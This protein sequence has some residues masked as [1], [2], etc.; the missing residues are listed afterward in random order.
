M[1]QTS[2][3]LR[4]KLNVGIAWKNGEFSVSRLIG[5]PQGPDLS[6]RSTT[7]MSTWPTLPGLRGRATAATCS[8]GS[9]QREAKRERTTRAILN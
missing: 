7:Q 6:L 3:P 8:C 1:K 5:V 2:L 9:A 4:L